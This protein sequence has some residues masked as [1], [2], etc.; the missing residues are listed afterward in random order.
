MH[1][2]LLRDVGRNLFH[3]H[4]LSWPD[5]PDSVVFLASKRE[6]RSRGNIGV[7]PLKW[8]LNSSSCDKKWNDHL[9]VL[10]RPRFCKKR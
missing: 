7:I 10:D 9:V 2:S 5:A 8:A 1:T 3:L 4:S 6:K